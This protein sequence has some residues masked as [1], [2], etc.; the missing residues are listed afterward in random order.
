[1]RVFIP[2]TCCLSLLALSACASL[3]E[4][5]T[6][7]VRVATRP[8]APSDCTLT[9]ERGAWSGASGTPVIVKRSRTD[10]H[11]VCT[12]R[13]TGVAG[14][15]VV[16]SDIEGWAF[17][18][19]LLGGLIGL[20]VDWGTGAA[21]TYPGD[22]TVALRDAITPHPPATA[23]VPAPVAPPA[24]PAP[25]LTPPPPAATGI[26]AAPPVFVVPGRDY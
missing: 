10:L 13:T 20:G 21:Y 25:A 4:G 24:V 6:D 23:T 16:A 7:P 18:N 11:V 8:A 12:D 2:V 22:V 17:G 15:Q 1:M 3:V 5:S 26:I 9:N 19:I 14:K